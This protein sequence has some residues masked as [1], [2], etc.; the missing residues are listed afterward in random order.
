LP[1]YCPT[2]LKKALILIFF[3]NFYDRFIKSQGKGE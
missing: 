3:L 2:I 1:N